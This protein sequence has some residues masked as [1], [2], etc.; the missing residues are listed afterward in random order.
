MNDMVFKGVNFALV[1]LL[2]LFFVVSSISKIIEF[3]SVGYALEHLLLL[4]VAMLEIAAAALFVF[5]SYLS[6][7]ILAIVIGAGG[8][9]VSFMQSASDGCGCL[10]RLAQLTRLEQRG[11]ACAIGMFG[12]LIFLQQRTIGK[13]RA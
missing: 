11:L 12:A 10:G 1:M 9:L 4:L 2:T 8:V 13:P 7:S 3:T 5:R 6:A